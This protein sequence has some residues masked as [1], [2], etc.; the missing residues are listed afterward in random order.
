M[1]RH[2]QERD[3]LAPTTRSLAVR[4]LAIVVLVVSPVFATGSALAVGGC[5]RDQ[6]MVGWFG[7][8]VTCLDTGGWSTFVHDDTDVHIGQIHDIAIC[9]D[10]IAWVADTWGLVAV[11]NGVWSDYQDLK[12]LELV[13]TERLACAPAGGV[14]IG[15]FNDLGYFDG[16]V[17]NP[18]DIANLGPQK[19][20][21][22]IKDLAV[23]P[24]GSLWVLSTNSIARLADGRWQYWMNGRG[25][26]TKYDYYF[27]AM[28]IDRRGV[29]WAAASSALIR[30][31][32]SKWRNVLPRSLSQPQAL[33]ADAKNRLW[34]GTYS[35]GL[36]MYDGKSWKTY[37]IKNSGLASND[38]TSLAIDSAGRIWV[39]TDWGISILSGVRWTTY[40]METAGIPANDAHVIAVM[41]RGPSLPTKMVKAKGTLTGRLVL[42]GVGQGG[43]TVEVCSQ[44]VGSMFF[45][46]SPCAGQVFHKLTVTASD[47]RFSVA[48]P[49]GKYGLTYKGRNGKWVRLTDGYNIGSRVMLVPEG[50]SFD[51]GDL[52]LAKVK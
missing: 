36:A 17:Y 28:T 24:D 13:D 43:L 41:G 1:F 39:A 52:D 51:I 12:T 2:A 31:N 10:G 35:K 37:T 23:G 45:G 27:N 4:I 46:T 33:V 40:R 38:V 34:V 11:R 5:G 8:G 7:D 48:L 49:T 14:F 21:G 32:G 9:P 29:A 19:Y 22:S 16:S 50:G 26:S 18:I 30:F 20:A 3:R 44:F 25:Y 47:G 15:G 6:A 42:N